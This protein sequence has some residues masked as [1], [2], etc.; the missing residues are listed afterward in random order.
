MITDET[1]TDLLAQCLPAGRASGPQA[2]WKLFKQR[3]AECNYEI[4]SKPEMAR[5]LNEARVEGQR[6]GTSRAWA[7]IEAAI[8]EIRP[9]EDNDE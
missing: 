6:E 1:F 9:S 8:A 2:V 3:L 4:V 5:A 7:T